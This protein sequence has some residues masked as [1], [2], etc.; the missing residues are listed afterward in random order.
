VEPR[1]SDD[2]VG[3]EVSASGQRAKGAVKDAAGA[4]TGNRSLEREGE[5]ENAAGRARQASNNVMD[6]TDG[7]RGSTAGGRAPS[8]AGGYVTGLYST[9]E[10][11][12]RAYQDL[13]TRHGYKSDDINVLMT[14]ETRRR[15]F[16]DVKPGTELEGGTKAA[17]GM[18]VGGAIGG[19]V[20]AAMAAIFAVGTSVAIP[21]LGLVV[22]GPI[23]AALAGAGAGAATGGLIGALVGA[24]I[25]EERAREYERGL[26]NGG[27]VIGTR[28]RDAAHA[29]QLEKDFG[30]YGGTNVRS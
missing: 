17:E 2:T 8:T 7:V 18:G 1:K 25:P 6:E 13:T 4:M 22:A 11:A 10:S 26:N 5:R 3:E 24:G 29:A 20:G 27:I 12:S 21:G 14:D 15:H 16:G 28:P 19:G 30:S 9:P 23:A